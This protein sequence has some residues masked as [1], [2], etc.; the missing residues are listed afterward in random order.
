MTVGIRGTTPATHTLAGVSGTAL[1]VTLTG[2][3]QPQ[4]GDLLLIF[5]GNNFFALTNMPTPSVGGSTSGVTLQATCDAGTNFSHV[6][7]YTY[8]VA[9]TGDRTV[10]VT[11]T[12]TGDEER[13]LVVYVLSGADT[14]SPIDGTPS[15]AF[16]TTAGTS[17]V[18]TSVT[19][20]ASDSMLFAHVGHGPSAGGTS[21]TPPSAPWVEDYDVDVS[22]G[23]AFRSSGGHEQL[24]AAGATGTRTF[25]QVG[26][27]S[28]WGSVMLAVEASSGGATASADIGPRALLFGPAFLTPGGGSAVA[29]FIQQPW[30]QPLWTAG[31]DA[32]VAATVSGDATLAGTAGITA[33]AAVVPAAT[34]SL[35]TS[36]GITATAATTTPGSAS[37]TGTAAITAAAAVV[38]PAAASLTATATLTSAAGTAQPGQASLTAT[39]GITA[40]AALAQPAQAAVTTTATITAAAAV[41]TVAALTATATLTATAAVVRPATASLTATGTLTA[42]AARTLPATATL[43]ATAAITAAADTGTYWG[44]PPNF[45]ATP[46]SDTQIDLSWSAVTGASGYDIER[47]GAVIATDATGTSYSD[48]GLAAGTSYSYRIRSV[49]A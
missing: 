33:T 20:T 36:A 1:T 41:G 16:S 25:T 13:M 32:V 44:P 26:G 46:V 18:L 45:T 38:T 30:A 6:K 3:R 43:T 49:R 17:R 19:T 42:A 4:A 35:T 48:T 29:E 47:D 31:P 9:S 34:A 22:G 11:E 39:A 12:G 37:L 5:H 14:T 7:A 21:V 24:S 28:E 27:S 40:S 15:T 2:T 23:S 10:T 8:V